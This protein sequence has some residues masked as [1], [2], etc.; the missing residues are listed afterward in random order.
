MQ[1]VNKPPKTR[2]A[3]YQRKV[4]LTAEAAKNPGDA[5]AAHG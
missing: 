1:V 4:I 3:K 5:G 2:L